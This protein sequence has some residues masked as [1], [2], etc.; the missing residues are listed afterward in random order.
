MAFNGLSKEDRKIIVKGII[1]D[2]KNVAH[3]VGNVMPIINKLKQEDIVPF[4]KIIIPN[5]NF[6]LLDGKRVVANH[7]SDSIKCD[8]WIGYWNKR[9]SSWYIDH[10]RAPGTDLCMQ[11]V[12]CN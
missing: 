4:F 5:S 11:Y 7:H 8:Y 3:I 12:P 6:I 1:M 10:C 2:N 9:E